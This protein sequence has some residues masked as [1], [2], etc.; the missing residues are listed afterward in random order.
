MTALIGLALILVGAFLTRSVYRMGLTA[1][2]RLGYGEGQRDAY[3]N[4]RRL[5]AER[6][7]QM[8]G[9]S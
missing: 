8:G 3:A 1:G 4:A 5:L 6:V 2:V 7:E 9:E